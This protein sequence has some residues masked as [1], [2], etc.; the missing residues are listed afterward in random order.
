MVTHSHAQ[1]ML[2]LY[3]SSANVPSHKLTEAI[4]LVFRRKLLPGG[5]VIPSAKLR[6]NVI[7]SWQN[8]QPTAI[9]QTPQNVEVFTTNQ[10]QTTYVQEND[11]TANKTVPTLGLNKRRLFVSHTFPWLKASVASFGRP[12]HRLILLLFSGTTYLILTGT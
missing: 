5:V 9:S 10:K 8:A 11:H 6:E 2:S 3:K 1:A 12:F 7:P 4:K